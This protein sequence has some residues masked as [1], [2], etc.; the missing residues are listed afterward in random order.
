MVNLRLQEKE[1]TL[2][3]SEVGDVERSMDVPA[4]LGNTKPVFAAIIQ[5]DSDSSEITVKTDFVQ[6]RS[7]VY[8][9]ISIHQFRDKGRRRQIFDYE[10]FVIETLTVKQLHA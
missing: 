7:R 8:R 2:R 5:I 1:T 10:V 3:Q 4:G 6:T 9:P